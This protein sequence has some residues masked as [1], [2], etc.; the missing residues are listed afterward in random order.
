MLNLNNDRRILDYDVVI[1][2][3]GAAGA[4]AAIEAA[5]NGA[6]VLVLDR[7]YGGGATALSG[8]IIYAGGG[9]PYQKEAGFDDTPEN[10]FQYLKLETQG[11]VSDKLLKMFCDTSVETISWLEKQ[12]VEFKSTLCPYKTSYPTDRHYL[13]YSGNEKAYPYKNHAE[14]APRG[15]RTLAPGMSSGAVFF[16]HLQKSALA[17]GIT[18]MPISRA[19]SLIIEND[20]VVGLKFRSMIKSSR[21]HRT[22]SKIAGKLGNWI[23]AIANVFNRKAD[24]IWIKNAEIVEVRAASTIL[25]AG[26]FAFNRDMVKS[27]AYPYRNVQPLG[28]VADDGKGILLGLSAKGAVAQMERMTCWR[29]L[30]PPSAFIEGITTGRNGKRITNEDLYGASFAEAFIHEHDGKG[31]LI[32]DHRTWKKAKEQVKTQTLPFQAAQYL[33]LSTFGHTKARTLEGLLSKID[34]D[35][36]AAIKTINEYNHNILNSGDI[37]HKDPEYCFPIKD[38]PFYAIDISVD[39][40]MFFGALGISLG[41]LV[42]DDDTGV[43]KRNDGSLIKGL[44]A[45]GRNAVGICGNKYVSGLS[46]ADCVF[47]GRK[48]GRS[49]TS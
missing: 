25:S 32:L 16:S 44:Y 28:T 6:R 27:F 20:E 46:I 45:A 3:F 7:A 15:H 4:S 11:C 31:F 1:V 22:Y 33:Y 47:S 13:Y 18:F 12:G 29:F 36:S 40:S 23:P 38:G 41:G 21:R 26:G 39:V 43:V 19:E 30:S 48:A 24:K 34:V 35:K 9:T 2:G 37:L 5:D 42:T 8:G 14:P 49:A 10:M 17:K